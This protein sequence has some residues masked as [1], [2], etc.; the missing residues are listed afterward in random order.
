MLSKA[1]A[2]IDFTLTPQY[3]GAQIIRQ[4]S[5]V[6]INT[7]LQCRSCSGGC[8]FTAAMDFPPN[9][10]IRLLQFGLVDE[11]LRSST[12][13]TCVA[14]NTCSAQCP[15]AIDIPAV[16][17]VM[18]QMAVE[19]NIAVAEPDVLAFHREI[20]R[21][22]EKYG[23]THKLEIMLRYKLKTRSLFSD[24]QTGLR[25]FA[26]KKLDLTPSRVQNTA[27]LKKLM[28]SGRE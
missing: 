19:K 7:C 5:G 1:T 25:M 6:N 11:A 21:S 15:M 17:D 27:A 10:L 4:H 18:R 28:N 9:H 26:K 14:C 8:P 24:V 3:D 22:I 23:R 13:W 2:P 12:I 16:M 20:M